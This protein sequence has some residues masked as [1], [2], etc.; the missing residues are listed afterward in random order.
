M[1]TERIHRDL[2][3]VIEKSGIFLEA[4]YESTTETSAPSW[5]GSSAR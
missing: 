4:T 1:M 3:A 5:S 2:T